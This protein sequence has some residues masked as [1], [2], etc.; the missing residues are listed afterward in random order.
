V[1]LS[2]LLASQ[3]GTALAG[4][5]ARGL[6]LARLVAGRA[7]MSVVQFSSVIRRASK[8]RSGSG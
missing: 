5:R 7:R 8:R 1:V 4:Y 3:A 6:V 2:G